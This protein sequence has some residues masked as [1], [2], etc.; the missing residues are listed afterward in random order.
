M[1]HCCGL[2]LKDVVCH[3]PGRD[4][5]L[6]RM[7]ASHGVPMETSTDGKSN[8]RHARACQP[9]QTQRDDEERHRCG[10]RKMTNELFFRTWRLQTRPARG[11]VRVTQDSTHTRRFAKCKD[12]SLRLRRVT[13]HHSTPSKRSDRETHLSDCALTQTSTAS[14]SHKMAGG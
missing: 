13:S 7:Y 2:D 10:Q 1:S 9:L 3:L 14:T 5:S 12:A 8:N 4:T 11:A 6:R